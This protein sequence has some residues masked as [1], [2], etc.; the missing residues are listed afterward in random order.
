M[1]VF[2][3]VLRSLLEV[4]CNVKLD[5]SC[6]LQ[7]SLPI[8]SGGLRIRSA[9]MLAPSAYLASASC[10]QHPCFSGHPPSRDA[11]L[12][13]FIIDKSVKLVVRLCMF[14]RPTMWPRSIFP[15]GMGCVC[16]YRLFLLPYHPFTG[17]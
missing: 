3:A 15:E 7:A 14:Q 10:W 16:C 12:H 1:S 4:I 8:N 9:V 5:D 6:W 17:L 2:D 13:S 11:V